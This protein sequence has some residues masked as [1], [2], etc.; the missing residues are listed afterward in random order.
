[1][2][3]ITVSTGNSEWLTGSGESVDN[4]SN[5]RS[6]PIDLV[7]DG[8]ARPVAGSIASRNPDPS[9]SA[10]CTKAEIAQASGI[11]L[12]PKVLEA[13]KIL[14]LETV[15]RWHALMGDW[16]PE[17]RRLV[18]TAQASSVIA[19]SVKTCVP[20]PAWRTRNVTLLATRFTT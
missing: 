3:T 17:L 4:R 15:L 12:S 2:T 20:I 13:L 11:S 14:K 18:E 1:L 8:W 9:T 16:A 7:R 19:F 10:Q 6:L 5:E